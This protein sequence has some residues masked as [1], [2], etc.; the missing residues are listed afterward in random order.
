MAICWILASVFVGFTAK[1]QDQLLGGIILA[2]LLGGYFWLARNWRL[3]GELESDANQERLRATAKEHTTCDIEPR[4]HIFLKTTGDEVIA[5]LGIA[6]SIGVLTKMM[7]DRAIRLK[8]LAESVWEGWLLYPWVVVAL[9]F[10]TFAVLGAIEAFQQAPR[11]TEGIV[12]V[13]ASYF[14]LISSPHTIPR[15]SLLFMLY[16]TLM[17]VLVGLAWLIGIVFMRIPLI[18]FGDLSAV[19]AAFLEISVEPFPFGAVQTYHA[20]WSKGGVGLH[21]SAGYSNPE[22]IDTIASWMMLRLNDRKFMGLSVH[23]GG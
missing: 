17:G 1:A 22:A 7:Q 6:Q 12:A 14:K 13:V 8:N 10:I 4:K 16:F 15:L 20:K 18:A 5:G 2:V 3:L 23:E 9:A 21:H 11:V 19:V